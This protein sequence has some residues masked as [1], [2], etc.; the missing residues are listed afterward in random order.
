MSTGDQGL[1]GDERAFEVPGIEADRHASLGLAAGLLAHEF[2]ILLSGILLNAGVLLDGERGD[3]QRARIEMIAAKARRGADLTASLL[4]ASRTLRVDPDDRDLLA[5]AKVAV[6]RIAE[7]TGL[8]LSCPAAVDGSPVRAHVDA[9]ACVVAMLDVV[10]AIRAVLRESK[11]SMVVEV[12]DIEADPGARRPGAAVALR[13]RVNGS[14]DVAAAALGD[15]PGGD[16]AI[17]LA[18]AVGYAQ[19]SRGS[20]RLFVAPSRGETVFEFR[21]PK[22]L[23]DAGREAAPAAPRLRILVVD[24]DADLADVMREGLGLRGHDAEACYSGVAAL[25]LLAARPWDAVVSDISMPGMS[26]YQ[27]LEAVQDRWPGLPVLLMT[28]FSREIAMGERRIP[29]R[30][31]QKP[32]EVSKLLD[33]LASL[34]AGRRAI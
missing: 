2:N 3:S 15:N 16:W 30:I 6:R 1:A 24:D 8:D 12:G 5:I 23:L 25:D 19:A 26:G 11:P 9:D 29:A 32:V 18:A 4:A 21:L 28:A 27:L 14:A 22:A 33:E 7:E 17:R 34:G 31:F 10:F 20:F 13:L